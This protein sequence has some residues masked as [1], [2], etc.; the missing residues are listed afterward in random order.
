MFDDFFENAGKFFF[1]KIRPSFFLIFLGIPPLVSSFFLFQ[2]KK[3]MEVF[4][5]QFSSISLKAKT[6][7]EK[8]S[9]K[10]R[11]LEIHKNSNP[12]FL[13]QEIESLSFL[14]SEKE[15]IKN[16]L[17]HPAIANKSILQKR[18]HFLESNQNRLSFIDEEIQMSKF[19]KETIEKQKNSIELDEEDL[20]NLLGLIEETNS[21]PDSLKK[22]RPQLIISDFSITKKN[23]PLQNEVL[24]LKMDILKREFQNL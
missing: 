5:G 12:Y 23:T 17:S 10:E 7:F 11:F 16:W 6:A 19:V 24:E 18:L 22:N 14:C 13:D 8:K 9:R 20:K 21:N 15:R 3:S 4:Q 2:E 1:Q